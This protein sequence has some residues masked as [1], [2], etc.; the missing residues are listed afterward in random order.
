MKGIRTILDQDASSAR[1]IGYTDNPERRHAE[2]KRGA[3]SMEVDEDGAQGADPL[4][5]NDPW[6]ARAHEMLRPT[7]RISSPMKASIGTPPTRQPKGIP[8]NS[9]AGQ[10]GGGYGPSS[11]DPRVFRLPYTLVTEKDVTIK[12]FA[13]SEEDHEPYIKWH[14]SIKKYVENKITNAAEIDHL[15]RAMEWAEKEVDVIP[16]EKMAAYLRSKG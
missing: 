10:V 16:K 15:M 1:P 3:S 6:T 8:P 2:L 12:K 13:G 9:Y 14:D 7:R 4:Q 5:G 11:V